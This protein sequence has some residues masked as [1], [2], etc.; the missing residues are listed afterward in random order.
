MKRSML[1]NIMLSDE[2]NTNKLLYSSTHPVNTNKANKLPSKYAD[3]TDF[4]ANM[5]A[6]FVN[7][8]EPKIEV[9]EIK[10]LVSVFGN[11]FCPKTENW[12]LEE[13]DAD[14]SGAVDY[15]GASVM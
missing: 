3:A 14:G 13:V 10:R 11:K 9:G 7:G 15:N 12:I 4:K 8:E 2:K 1:P 6:F 5:F